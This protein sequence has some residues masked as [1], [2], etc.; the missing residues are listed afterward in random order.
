MPKVSDAHKQQVREAILDAAL[1][2]FAQTGYEG[3]SVDDVAAAAKKSVG[4]LYN[5]F[6]SKEQIFLALAMRE[7]QSD[8]E[9]IRA[10][11][12]AARSFD[13]ALGCLFGY[14]L[15]GF[16]SGHDAFP[17]VA[18]DFWT[19]TLTRP[20]VRDAFEEDGQLL[21]ETIAAELC[22]GAPEERERIA[23]LLI[24]LTDGLIL[25]LSHGVG[26][27]PEELR[28]LGERLRGGSWA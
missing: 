21:R 22:F 18:V 6:P 16:R 15:H 28:T 25:H 20:E 27:S 23:Q 9:A 3:T 2:C 14:V 17:R 10:N 12:H 13:E 4:T 11:L 5:Y 7:L 1:G 19:H 26:L 24:A 8:L